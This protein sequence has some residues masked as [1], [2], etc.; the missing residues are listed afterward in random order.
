MLL[1]PAVTGMVSLTGGDLRSFILG[2]LKGWLQSALTESG[3]L[4]RVEV[5]KQTRSIAGSIRHLYDVGS[6]TPAFLIFLFSV[7]VPFAKSA[8]VL[9]ALLTG[10]ATRRLHYLSLVESAGKWSMADVFVVGLFVAFLCSAAPAAGDDAPPLV[11]FEAELGPG[12]YWFTAY[13]LVSLATHQHARQ[14]FSLPPATRAS[15]DV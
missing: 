14:C 12:F 15:H 11:A 6:W 3:S 9:V 4:G 2:K 5:Y 13:C 8:L 10:D 7:A 1:N